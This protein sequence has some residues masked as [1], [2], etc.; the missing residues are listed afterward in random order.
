MNADLNLRRLTWVIDALS[1]WLPI[2][3]SFKKL[4][5][6]INPFWKH[7]SRKHD[8]VTLR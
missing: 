5:I 8:S 3:Y 1:T 7:N 4:P 2:A 6:I